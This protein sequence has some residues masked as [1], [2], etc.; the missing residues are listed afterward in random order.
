MTYSVV[1]VSGVQHRESVIQINT[2]ILFSHMD[3]YK[4][5]FLFFLFFL[6][7][8]L[9]FFLSFFLSFSLSLSFSLHSLFFFMAAPAAYEVPTRG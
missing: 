5:F 1:L 9:S 6:S 4:L 3:Y 8:S 2:A 7:F